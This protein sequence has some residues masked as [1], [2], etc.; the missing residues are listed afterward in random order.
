LVEIQQNH[1]QENE[2]IHQAGTAPAISV[3]K[4]APRYANSTALYFPALGEYL[5]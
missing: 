2:Q 1:Q 5:G 4:A 3:F